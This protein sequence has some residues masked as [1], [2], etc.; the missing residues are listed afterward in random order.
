MAYDVRFT[1]EAAAELTAILDYLADHSPQGSR[2]VQIRILEKISLVAE[3]PEVGP[4]TRSGR[5]RRIATAP[6]PY[7]VFYRIVGDTVEII[8]IRHGARRPSSMPK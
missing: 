7:I 8:G 6:Y 5:L 2:N 4:L 1:K 3:Q